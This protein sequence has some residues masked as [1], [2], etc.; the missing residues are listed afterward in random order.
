MLYSFFTSGY[1]GIFLVTL[2]LT[3]CKVGP[4]FHSPKA[5]QTS[6]YIQ[7]K[8]VKKTVAIKSAGAAGN[9]QTFI[10]GETIPA[11][12]WYLFHSK[13]LNALV[14]AGMANSP[15]LAASKAA[16]AQAQ[17]NYMAQV[18]TLF[19]AIGG[20]FTG[21]RQRFS[22]SQFGGANV[23]DVGS[24]IFNLFNTNVSVSYVLDVFGGLRRQIESSGAQVDFQ[25]FELEAA[26]LT[27]TSNIVTTAI[28]IAALKAQIGA[29]QQL[30][31]AQKRTLTIVRQQF[32]LGGV[33]KTEVL[34]QENQLAQTQS[35]LMPLEQNLAVNFHALSALVGGL[36]QEDFL[37]TFTLNKLHL[38]TNI[39]VSCPS[40]LVRQRPDVRA[41]EALLHGASAQ[42][43][44][45]IANMLPQINLTGFYGQQSI[46]L[47][48]LFQGKN[49][50]WSIAGA[51]AQPI[52]QGG[53]L[54][55]RKRAAVAAFDQAAAEYRQTVLLA[56]Q[57]V[58]DALRALQH[59]AQLLSDLIRAEAAAKNSLFLAR[60]QFGLGGVD[61]LSLLITERAYQQAVIG[62]IQAQ[63]ARYTDTA[64][65]FQALGG[66][67]WNRNIPEIRRV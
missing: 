24:R 43:G 55:S 33:S 34:L 8:P 11:D 58:A 32:A 16:L 2:T 39:P 36:P 6:S 60:Q 3:A 21:Q 18:G 61:Y 52:F 37:Q 66:G 31:A 17:A 45:A 19:P 42:I 49:N 1:T 47:S 54:I 46:S 26:N 25:A 59:D 53:T 9:S 28:T 38:P 64:A 5:P 22:L 30:I 29:T 4:N 50:I 62:R 56:F 51:A 10:Y 7:G 67:W 15:T 63:A 57:N 35:T 65:L 23:T 48:T 12:W 14:E 44:V 40:S 27:L 20:N 13:E 41:A